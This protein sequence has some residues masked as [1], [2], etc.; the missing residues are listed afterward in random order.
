VCF[1]TFTKRTLIDFMGN[2]RCHPRGLWQYVGKRS[3]NTFQGAAV[4]VLQHTQ[5]PF[6][7]CFCEKVRF[8]IDRGLTDSGTRRLST[9]GEGLPEPHDDEFLFVEAGIL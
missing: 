1:L 2:V 9:E 5:P 8:V 6:L 7:E 4:K 3:N